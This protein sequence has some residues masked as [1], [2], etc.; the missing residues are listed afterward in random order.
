MTK[1]ISL[2]PQL[3][4]GVKS[5]EFGVDFRPQANLSHTRFKTEQ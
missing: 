5:A 4:E 3:V 2:I 1:D